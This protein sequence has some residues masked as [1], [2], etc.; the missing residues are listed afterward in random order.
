MVVAAIAGAILGTCCC[1][2][3]IVCVICIV[4]RKNTPVAAAVVHPPSQVGTN[5]H[6]VL[7]TPIL[8]LGRILHTISCD[9]LRME[10]VAHADYVVRS[11]RINA[12]QAI[13]RSKARCRMGSSTGSRSMGSR[14]TGSRST[15]RVD[16]HSSRALRNTGRH[17]MVSSTR[18]RPSSRSTASRYR[19][20]SIMVLPDETK[21][22]IFSGRNIA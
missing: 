16:I 10:F 22:P 1:C 21:V 11:R 13:P 20:S 6:N 7:L 18:L 2:S 4:R 15:G 12:A 19:P 9:L 14:S 5:A 8:P 17:S 3:T